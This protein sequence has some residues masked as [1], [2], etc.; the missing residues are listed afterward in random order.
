MT[1]IPRDVPV[2]RLLGLW[3]LLTPGAPA[4]AAERPN[5]VVILC[6]DLG[7]GDLGSYGNPT[8]RTPTL[9]RLVSEG[10]RFTDC[11]SASPLCSPARCGLLTGRS[12]SR[13]G[14]YSW[15]AAG[16][17][18]HLRPEEVTMATL[19]RD[20]GY[21]TCH[22]G[23]W[24]LNGHFNDPRHTQPID[25]GFD[26]W[27]STQN[28]AAPSHENPVNFV[29]NGES[30]GPLEGFSCGLVASEAVQWL[31]SRQVRAE[32]LPPF[33]LFVCFH[34]PHEPV[35]SPA[36]LVESYRP[37]AKN[38]DQAHY[39]ASVENMDRAVRNLLEGLDEVGV[40][41]NTLV[42]FTSDNG[43]ETLNRYPAARRSYGSPGT[44][45][46]MKLHTYEG[47]IRVP[48]IV[49][50]P[51]RIEP[52]TVSPIPVCS[53]DLL[54][55]VCDILDLP[56][57]EGKRLD[58]TSLLP[59]LENRPLERTQ[60]LFWH[61][62]GAI[63]NRQ[64]ALRD[65]DWKLV[66][67]W[68]GAADLPSGGSLSPGVVPVLKQSRL[69]DFE[70]Y[71]LVRDPGEQHDLSTREPAQLA[72]MKQMAER[73]YHEVLAEGPDWEFPERLAN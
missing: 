18:M 67:G 64:V 37:V 49:R 39:F 12:P 53:L 20:A 59:V 31:R 65:G 36:E 17:P 4:P 34:E 58:G 19:L 60:P 24:H 69:K 44:L 68:D 5:I 3:C 15:I 54:P 11:Y 27:F 40:T 51:G 41:E 14:I 21:D 33:L 52:G 57:P 30:V 16:N 73:L 13:C 50:W 46:G 35:A 10:V 25:H 56:L 38:V 45:R 71:H 55:T 72:R 1:L 42:V 7:Y 26:D 8:I 66:A 22:V 63:G 32:R 43:P 6:D 48:G 61:Y 47:G 28:N 2:W 23:K 29:R 62:Y 70:L 9:D